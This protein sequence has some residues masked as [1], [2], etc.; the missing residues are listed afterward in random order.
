MNKRLLKIFLLLLPVSLMW[1]CGSESDEPTTRPS[2][3]PAPNP[4]QIVLKVEDVVGCWEVVQ[5]KFEA[6][7]AWAA[8][9]YETTSATFYSDGSYVGEGY[10]GHGEGRYLVAG[11]AITTTVDGAPYIT[12][13]VLSLGDDSAEM[14]AQLHSYGTTIWMLCERS[15]FLDKEPENST[16]EENVINSESGAKAVLSKCY[17][18]L[19]TLLTQKCTLEETL[20]A[21]DFSAL[22]PQSASIENLWECAYRLL[23]E[24]NEALAALESASLD[25][26]FTDSCC[27][28][29]QAL[30][31]FTAY[32]LAS[33]WGDVPY[34]EGRVEVNES[35]K[36]LKQR[37]ILE[38]AWDGL[39]G[40]GELLFSP[41]EATLNEAAVRLI[42]A[43]IALTSNEHK[44]ALD[45]L[46]AIDTTPFAG[47]SIFACYSEGTVLQVCYTKAHIELLR[48]EAN[49]EI[50]E[51][52][53]AWSE[54]L[55]GRWQML[56]RIGMAVEITGCEEH[57]CLLPIPD[58]ELMMNPALTQNDGY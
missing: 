4:E 25:A 37:E 15:E 54:Q 24:T 44:R 43:E 56:H 3:Q 19:C 2:E 46:S 6:E 20:L 47:E 29:L 49:K 27:D 36:P 5:A 39:E 7:G 8:W 45:I 14:E 9:P 1:S 35:L 55:Y 38:A 52:A 18:L 33:L 30:R 53:S 26:S 58:S 51:L 57:H 11:N 23:R 12:Y 10:F 50:A 40:I 34:Y 41:L 22:S 31:G 17:Y 13:K 21:G 28:Q 42:Q 16:S 32:L 48:Q